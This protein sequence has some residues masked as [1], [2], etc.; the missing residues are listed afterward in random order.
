MLDA[1]SIR[2]N[3]SRAA[4]KTFIVNW[5][6]SD[7]AELAH[8]EICN[9]VLNHRDGNVSEAHATVTLTRS[10]IGQMSLES[11]NT[12]QFVELVEA[13]EG[14]VDVVT[15]L[16]ELLDHFPHWFPVASHDYKFE[17]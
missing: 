13:I 15:E 2:L 1:L 8:S 3:A 11:L 10:V 14:D 4:E 6:L 16:L 9:C 5:I 12:D 17:E 7:S